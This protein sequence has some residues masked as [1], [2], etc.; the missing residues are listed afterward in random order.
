MVINSNPSLAYLMRDNTLLLQILTIAHVY[1]HNDFFKN[2]FTFQ[3]TR[4]EYVLEMFKAHASRVRSYM[5]DPSIGVERVER[6]L[7]AAHALSLQCRRNLAI[8]KL[9]IDKERERLSEHIPFE[10]SSDPAE[11]DPTEALHHRLPPSPEADLLLFIRDFNSLLSEWEK[12][13]LSIV[14]EQA[15]YFLPQIETKIMN[16][17]WASFW[18]REILT[19][20]ELP[21]GLQL[22]FL[23]RHNQ[24]VRPAPGGL[25]P[26]HLGLELWDSIYRDVTGENVTPGELH[27]MPEARQ[28]MMEVRAADRDTSFLRRFLTPDLMRELDL[29]QHEAK[30]DDLVITHVADEESWQDIKETL[31]QTIGMGAIPV[32]KIEDV[33]H[34]KGGSL[35][36]KH[37]HD[38]RDLQ[39]EAAQK[40]LSYIH[41]L[42]GR[43]VGLE[44]FLAEKPSLLTFGDAGFEVQ[45]A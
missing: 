25:N 9:P 28:K 23:V 18:H 16:E 31:L 37:Y 34:K 40:T 41:Q 11:Q 39:L 15:K 5:E 17:G 29:F 13:L 21:E 1:G 27:D 32:I 7:D 6:I 36:L 43:D 38:G 19:G 44:T 35:H 8:T 45:A 20:L 12:D 33:D 26:Y 42:W 22:E 14:D 4:P 3:T 10:S 24:V 30:G 2:N